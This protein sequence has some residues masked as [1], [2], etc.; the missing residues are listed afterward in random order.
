MVEK[1]LKKLSNIYSEKNFDSPM[2]NTKTNSIHKIKSERTA[3]NASLQSVGHESMNTKGK[4]ATLVEEFRT[5]RLLTVRF[6]EL[7]DSDATVL[8]FWPTHTHELPLLSTFARRFLA[9]SGTNVLSQ[10]AFFIYGFIGR[11]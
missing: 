11:K 2:P 10:S 6:M 8:D 1:E 4:C 9:T 3:V 7:K 5:Y